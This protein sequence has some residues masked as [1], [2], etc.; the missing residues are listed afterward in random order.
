MKKKITI[1][2]FKKLLSYEYNESCDK[3]IILDDY[4]EEIKQIV[5]PHGGL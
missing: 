1:V 4:I 3:I 2:A 5:K